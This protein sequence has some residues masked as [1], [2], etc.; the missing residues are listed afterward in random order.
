MKYSTLLLMYISYRTKNN[1]AVIKKEEVK[2]FLGMGD[3]CFRSVMKYLEETGD[4][5]QISQ[6]GFYKT[7]KVN[8]TIPV[9]DFIFDNKLSKNDKELAAVVILNHGTEF[10]S[11]KKISK[12][13]NTSPASFA[14]NKYRFEQNSEID[15]FEFLQKSK[16]V[17]PK[18]IEG[19][20]I[21][22]GGAQLAQ[23]K[24][25]KKISTE[26]RLKRK[27]ANIP[28][29]LFMASKYNCRYRKGEKAEHTITEQDIK[30]Q[31]IKQDY[32]CYYTGQKFSEEVVPSIDRIDSSKGYISGNIVIVDKVINIMKQDLS[33]KQF[34]KYIKLIAANF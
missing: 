7:L 12:L 4:V 18:F 19:L 16:I 20:V 33:E 31:L 5:I 28:H 6:N 26:E 8:K 21:N 17:E 13:L 22:Q 15:F 32:K 25:K 14:Q 30:D 9:Y 1:L 29:S 10:I 11:N 27:L 3:D 2:N 23:R 24:N 34:L